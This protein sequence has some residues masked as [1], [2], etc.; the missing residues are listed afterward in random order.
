[1]IVVGHEKPAAPVIGV[2]GGSG[3]YDLDGLEKASWIDIETPFG[4]PSDQLLVGELEG[5]KVVFLPRHG[6]GHKFSP[7]TLNYRA[8]ICAL[9]MA[10]VTDILS[11]SA[12]GSLQE[13]LPPGTFVIVDQ[14]I[15]RTYARENSFFGTGLVAHVSMAHP[16]CSRLGDVLEEMTTTQGIKSR[17]GGTYLNMEGPQFSTLAE[18]NL[19]RSLGCAVVGMTNATEA[20]LAKE[21]EMCYATIAMV[22]DYDCWHPSHGAVSVDQVIKV[23]M[24]NADKARQIVRS[25]IP[26]L[27][28]R[29]DVCTSGCHRALDSSIIT[30]PEARDRDMINRL[31]PIAGRILG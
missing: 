25:M 30:A 27:K 24:E 8:N 22:T 19:Y 21:A 5:Q 9:K 12:C 1:M 23:L 28:A 4:R 15:D 17:R 11:M 2:I 13:E 16:V 26:K 3:I 7:S 10:G 14:F 31:M 20:K 18:S 6:R 29:E